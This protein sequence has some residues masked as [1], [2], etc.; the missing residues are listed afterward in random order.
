M[1][2]CYAS[3]QSPSLAAQRG[4]APHC[5]S[6]DRAALATAAALV[7]GGLLLAGLGIKKVFDTPSRAYDENVGQEYD[8]WTEEGVL[9]YYWGAQQ[10]PGRGGCLQDAAGVTL[11]AQCAE[12]GLH[13]S[14]SSA[15][16]H[17]HLGHYSEEV[18]HACG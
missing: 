4:H 18:R 7:A 5:A 12:T 6:V 1:Q 11:R 3:T 8:A 9:E 13:A 15:G 16:E 17:I 14:D 10:C 2:D